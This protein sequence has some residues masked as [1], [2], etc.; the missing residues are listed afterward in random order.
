MPWWT[1]SPLRATNHTAMI[2]P[3]NNLTKCSPRQHRCNHL[4]MRSRETM[5]GNGNLV[6]NQME[7]Q[8]NLESGEFSRILLLET[9][10]N[11]RKDRQIFK[12]LRVW[13][14]V[15]ELMTRIAC[16]LMMVRW[17]RVKIMVRA[18]EIHL[19]RILRYLW[20]DVLLEMKRWLISAL[21][22]L[23][24]PFLSDR[25]SLNSIFRLSRLLVLVELTKV[26][27]PRTDW[28]LAKICIKN[29]KIIQKWI[30]N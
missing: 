19:S 8:R 12:Y 6:R 5:A 9:T 11:F 26:R 23:R 22:V 28:M 25:V 24:I 13:G 21:K 27:F 10:N 14:E 4:L 17:S 30:A 1:S 16:S 29:N 20:Q 2:I 3:S 7:E 15:M 18:K